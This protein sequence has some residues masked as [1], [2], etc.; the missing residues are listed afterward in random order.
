MTLCLS[1]LQARVLHLESIFST[2]RCTSSPIL[3]DH[4]EA[5]VTLLA[6]SSWMLE[7]ADANLVP[8]LGK[9]LPPLFS[10]LCL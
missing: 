3:D 5:T 8:M 1:I 7:M 9:P 10:P 4:L 6:L 2:F